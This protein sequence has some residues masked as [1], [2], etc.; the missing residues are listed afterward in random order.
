MRISTM[1]VT[2][3]A[4]CEAGGSKNSMLNARRAVV[5]MIILALVAGA[6]VAQLEVGRK[7]PDFKVKT[8]TV[9]PSAS[10]P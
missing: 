10:S 5:S 9:S 8:S 1:E 4:R 6:A 7:A 3:F 2:G